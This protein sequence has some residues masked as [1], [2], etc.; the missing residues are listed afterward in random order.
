VAWTP[1]KEGLWT[2]LA[3][4]PGSKAYYPSFAQTS[5]S[6]TS[7]PSPIEIPEAPQPV[8]CTPQ[9]VGTWIAIAIIVGVYSIY[10]HRKLKV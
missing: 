1:P 4:F 7:A 6:V 3:T 9:F 8:D 5:I 10:D 2:I